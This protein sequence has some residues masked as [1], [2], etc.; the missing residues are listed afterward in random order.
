MNHGDEEGVLDGGLQSLVSTQRQVLRS[1]ISEETH[2]TSNNGKSKTARTP[3]RSSKDYGIV[4]PSQSQECCSSQN[5]S[6]HKAGDFRNRARQ[7]VDIHQNQGSSAV[8][9]SRNQLYHRADNSRNQGGPRIDFSQNQARCRVDDSQTQRGPRIG[10]LQKEACYKGH[11][12]LNPGHHESHIF[13]KQVCPEIEIPQN[14]GCKV[15]L[16][17]GNPQNQQS[18]GTAS[19]RNQGCAEG[20]WDMNWDDVNKAGR[21]SWRQ[22]HGPRK[23]GCRNIGSEDLQNEAQWDTIYSRMDSSP[24]SVRK[25]VDSVEVDGSRNRQCSGI[26]R[27]QDE[28]CGELGGSSAGISERQNGGDSHG[29]HDGEQEPQKWHLQDLKN[30]SS[31]G[32]DD[33]IELQALCRKNNPHS[34]AGYSL[35]TQNLTSSSQ[36]IKSVNPGR[37]MKVDLLRT[38]DLKD[39]KGP[40]HRSP[41]RQN[42]MGLQN[43]LS[44][45]F[46]A[47]D[48]VKR[49]LQKSSFCCSDSALPNRVSLSEKDRSQLNVSP[50]ILSCDDSD[51]GSSS[52]LEFPSSAQQSVPSGSWRQRLETR[53]WEGSEGRPCI[54][55]IQQTLDLTKRACTLK[56]PNPTSSTDRPFASVT[57]QTTSAAGPIHFATNRQLA[58]AQLGPIDL[59]TKKLGLNGCRS[60]RDQD[61]ESL[62]KSP[63][64]PSWSTQPKKP[65][66]AVE[67]C[68]EVKLEPLDTVGSSA[69]QRLEISMTNQKTRAGSKLASLLSPSV[70][71]A[72]GESSSFGKYLL[73]D[74]Q[75]MPYTVVLQEC[76]LPRNP[77]KSLEP[78]SE[79]RLYPRK[80]YSCTVCSMKFNYLSYLRRHS[81]THSENKPH[82]CKVCG[83]GFKRTSHLERHKYTHSGAKRYQCQVCQRSFRD[84][85]ELVHHM[86]Y[87]TGER[88]YQCGVCHMRFAERSTLQRHVRRK[89]HELPPPS[90]PD[91]EE[92]SETSELLSTSQSCPSVSRIGNLLLKR[93]FGLNEDGD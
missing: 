90:P 6:F 65:S 84:S 87:H 14:Q 12:P 8:D 28:R 20:P 55:F 45:H 35:R 67:N 57:N 30:G 81:I 86:R 89:Q 7:H 85:C 11:D 32:T 56:R 82:V 60:E 71:E 80:I 52:D 40:C 77:E 49:L 36:P 50:K 93:G 53:M 5:H 31:T 43:S 83:K 22:T 41:Q 27:S 72:S 1:K 42:G 48:T 38:Q 59:S 76:T 75:G 61:L 73:I 33:F 21:E 3:E 62:V 51:G 74:S 9:G 37:K 2:K 79:K 18:S 91:S 29:H 64:S 23:Q 26:G 58:S 10:C 54:S 88:P 47:T 4:D 19:S 17:P 25:R 78:T 16:G 46:G 70:E 69:E 24:N 66:K 44:A 39:Q 34:W 13:R 63:S 15:G 68:I 92:V